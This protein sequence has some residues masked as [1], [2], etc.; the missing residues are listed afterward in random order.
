MNV[1]FPGTCMKTVLYRGT[2]IL[3]VSRRAVPALQ[4][5]GRD[6]RGTHGRDAPATVV[7]HVLRLSAA[8]AAL[9]V[10]ACA[11]A[12]VAQEAAPVDH[13]APAEPATEAL[14]DRL[15]T[16]HDASM[17][18]TRDKL[19]ARGRTIEPFLEAQLTSDQWR[20][21]MAAEALL[22]RLRRPG[23]VASWE[24]ILKWDF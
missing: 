14:F 18:F 7:V 19:L 2:G 15:V 4:T 20:R 5:H 10:A 1:R 6:G 9:V 12:V 11:A 8:V 21:R 3:P 13:A 23:D 24:G 22:L 16:M 17:T